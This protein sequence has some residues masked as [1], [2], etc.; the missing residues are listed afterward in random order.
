[1]Y[2]CLQK[3]MPF[4]FARLYGLKGVGTVLEGSLQHNPLTLKPGFSDITGI[5]FVADLIR[6]SS[7][8]PVQLEG[9]AAG[10]SASI[11]E[12]PQAR[13]PE[14]GRVEVPRKGEYVAQPGA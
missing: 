6:L 8:L 14:V 13:I 7:H 9:V 4:R 1:M 12:L 10:C 2:L 11:A 5:L 3:A